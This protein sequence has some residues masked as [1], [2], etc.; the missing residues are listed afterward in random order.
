MKDDELLNSC[1]KEGNRADHVTK[2]DT[3][4]FRA[5]Q[6]ALLGGGEK[7][8]LCSTIQ[9]VIEREHHSTGH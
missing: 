9:R 6:I 2:V 7:A 1:F 5:L 8:S 3:F 4:R